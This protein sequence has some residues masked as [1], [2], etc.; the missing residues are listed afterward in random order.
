MI[1][2]N[3]GSMAEQLKSQ[4]EFT[5][6]YPS[7]GWYGALMTMDTKEMYMIDMA[8]PMVL[9]MTG[10]MVNPEEFPITEQRVL[11]AKLVVLYF[12]ARKKS[13]W[14]SPYGIR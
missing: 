8:E 10:M 4:A 14:Q 2:T 13:M 3:L 5:N 7:L 9:E 6:Y 12:N 1:T 11:R